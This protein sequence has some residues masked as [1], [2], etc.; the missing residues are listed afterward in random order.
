M[1]VETKHTQAAAMEALEASK[2]AND[3]HDH[4]RE[5]VVKL[6]RSRKRTHSRYSLDKSQA[7]PDPVTDQQADL[8]DEVHPLLNM[9]HMERAQER[10]NDEPLGT[11]LVTPAWQD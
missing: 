9:N 6:Q 3:W 10:E 7:V 4:L 11:S 1:A 2:E 5:L 8:A